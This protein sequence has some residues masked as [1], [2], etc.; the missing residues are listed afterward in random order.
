[1]TS[2]TVRSRLE[3]QGFLGLDDPTLDELAPWLRW[4]PVVCT[5]FMVLGVVTRSPV[6]LWGL[7]G[8]AFLGALL[9]FHP[10]DL[11]YNHGARYLTGTRPLPH[12]GPQRRFACGLASAW[13]VATGWAFQM[14]ADA[15]GYVLGVPL[16][17][18]AALVS[19]THICIP[20][21]IYGALFRRG[22]VGETAEQHVS[23]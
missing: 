1:M 8:V 5:V 23:S 15:L 19:I 13:L 9:P 6:V 16:A 7:A 18:V 3:T 20:S 12:H 11:L 21:M 14:G 10:F 2:S 22:T 4:S 17:L